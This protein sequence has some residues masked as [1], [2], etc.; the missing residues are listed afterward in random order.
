MSLRG[1][2]RRSNLNGEARLPRSRWSLAMT[3]A[4]VVCR[5]QQG[6]PQPWNTL[7]A[8]AV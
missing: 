7:R 4:K 6:L 5:A 1:A 2:K 8:G 3:T